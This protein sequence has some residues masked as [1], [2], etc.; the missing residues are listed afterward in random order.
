MIIT[1]RIPLPLLSY[2][3]QDSWAPAWYSSLVV[4]A[5]GLVLCLIFFLARTLV[6]SRTSKLNREAE[7]AAVGKSDVK[8][9]NEKG[10]EKRPLKW[11][12]RWETLE[13]EL[14]VSLS[15]SLA[16]PHSSSRS[17]GVLALSKFPSPPPTDPSSQSP[18]S[19]EAGG[20]NRL[21]TVGPSFD[22]PRPAIYE[23]EPLS[24]AKAIM[25]RHTYRRPSFAAP[26]SRIPPSRLLPK[27]LT[28][29]PARPSSPA[30][31][32][33]SKQAPA[34]ESTGGEMV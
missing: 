4:L 14:P 23:A 2:S 26:P 17:K 24:M 28:S 3:T 25:S 33:V 11:W 20:A 32:P 16:R 13:R 29:A 1:M 15:L 19:E 7:K 18:P 31:P 8:V 10:L 30:S 27:S 12:S 9:E 22:S 34:H 5:M 21:K 6:L